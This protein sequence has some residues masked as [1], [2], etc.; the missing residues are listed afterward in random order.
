MSDTKQKPDE[1]PEWVWCEDDAWDWERY[2]IGMPDADVKRIIEKIKH[3]VIQCHSMSYA[4]GYEDGAM[5]RDRDV[6]QEADLA[7]DAGKEAGYNEGFR[8]GVE[9][10]GKYHA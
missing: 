3:Q 2:L 1:I 10:E 8:D 4:A 5:Y 7:F 9:Q 6:R